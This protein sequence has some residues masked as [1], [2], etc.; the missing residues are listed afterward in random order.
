MPRLVAAAQVP[1]VVMHWRGPSRDMDRRAVYADVVREVCAELRERV[2]AVI[3]EGV[4][5]A[6]IVLDPGLGFGKLAEHNWALLTA[7]D[8]ISRLDGPALRFPC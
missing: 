7:V 2:D 1:Y 8:R 4:D 5:P 3:A 6:M